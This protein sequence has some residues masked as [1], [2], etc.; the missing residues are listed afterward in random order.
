MTYLI[1][2][3]TGLTA[4]LLAIVVM[5]IFRRRSAAPA[6]PAQ[7]VVPWWFR[8]FRGLVAFAAVVCF[9]ILAATGFY[10]TIF[11][12]ARLTGYPLMLHAGVSPVF[13]VC[14][15]LLAV[16]GAQSHACRCKSEC[17]SAPSAPPTAPDVRT[18]RKVCFW[19]ILIIAL[20]LI[21]SIA[22]SMLPLLGTQMQH[23]CF[24]VHRYSA[25]LITM[26]VLFYSYFTLVGRGRN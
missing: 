3:V 23:L 24:Q 12:G 5:T 10:P 6:K 13:A 1:L 25:L 2:L 9:A 19:L 16:F 22:L 14:L 8:A 20:P 17:Q 7:A 4:S 21:L 11:T 15:A 26:A 18:G